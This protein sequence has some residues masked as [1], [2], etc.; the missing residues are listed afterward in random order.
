MI[1]YSDATDGLKTE[2]LEGF[3]VGWPNPPSEETFLRLLQRTHEIVLA[4]DDE[5]GRV[6]G[7]ITAITDGVLA[8]YIPLLEVLPSYQGKKIGTELVRRMLDKLESYYM[9]DLVCDESKVPFYSQFPFRPA[10]AM[11]IRRF[12]RQSGIE[13]HA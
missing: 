7:F 5:N 10:T 13:E 8:A 6:V 3:F 12:E 11:T 4:I 1:R 2:N 9:V